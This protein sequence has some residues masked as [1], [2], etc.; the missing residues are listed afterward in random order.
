MLITY[1]IPILYIYYHYANHPSISAIICSNECQLIILVGMIVMGMLTLLYE[2]TRGDTISMYIILCLLVGIY[3]VILIN[4][5]NPIHYGFA[6]LVFVSIL[7]FMVH[8]TQKCPSNGLRML[9]L[10][11][12]YFAITTIVFFNE[13]IFLTEAL[14]IGTFAVYYLSLHFMES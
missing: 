6:G 7:G 1:S 2:R 12:A 11:A 13:S 3:G 10:I 8:H 4:E 14:F 9:L 5:T